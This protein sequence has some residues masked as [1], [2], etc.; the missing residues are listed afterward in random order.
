MQK[1]WPA[2]GYCVGCH[3]SQPAIDFLAPGTAEGAYTTIFMFQPPVID[4]E[5]PAAS[6][7][8][9]MGKHTGPAL[10]PQDAAAILAWIQAERDERSPDTGTPL[11]FGP[12]TVSLDAMNTIDLGHGASLQFHGGAFDSG[13]ELTQMQIATTSTAVHVVHPLFVSRPTN[14]PAVL[15][16]LDHFGDID[17]NVD[18]NKTLEL[19]S[20][21]FESFKPTDPITIHFRTLEAQ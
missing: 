21:L 3:G 11:V 2:F 13:L 8:L 10:Q 16:E 1:A 9:T 14:G 15:D 4:L 6:L 7:V 20:T 5:S 12:M 17:A 19:T 18:A